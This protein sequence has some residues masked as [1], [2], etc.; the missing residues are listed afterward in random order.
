MK[1]GRSKLVSRV[2]EQRPEQKPSGKRKASGIS[3]RAIWGIKMILAFKA[4]RCEAAA[5]GRRAE[6]QG[7]RYYRA[8]GLRMAFSAEKNK[9]KER[10]G[11]REIGRGTKNGEREREGERAR[12]GQRG[13][14]ET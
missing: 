3:E 13:R 14:E 11:R 5:R 1:P 7:G 8:L 4:M 12:R 10:E 9:E 6:E 2:F